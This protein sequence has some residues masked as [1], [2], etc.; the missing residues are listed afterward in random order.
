LSYLKEKNIMAKK[1]STGLSVSL[2]KLNQLGS[3]VDL[4]V[5]DEEE[6]Q[7]KLEIA[8]A[9]SVYGSSIFELEDGRAGYAFC[10]DIVNH[11]SRPIYGPQFELRRA[12][13]DP[14]FEWLPDPRDRH[15]NARNYYSFPG[16]GA[17]EFPRSQVLNHLLLLENGVL[18]PR[19]P[20]Q[21]YLLAVGG[22]MPQHL[23]HGAE[24]EPTLVVTTPGRTEYLEPIVLFTDRCS[25]KPK[26]RRKES[27]LYEG[28]AGNAIAPVVGESQRSDPGSTSSVRP[29]G[30]S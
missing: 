10:V 20:Y 28:P 15:R 7:A 29:L 27:S 18:Q 6:E 21:G 11:A 8:Q 30:R 23:H 22:P 14:D 9:G 26:L 17:P 12:W 3:P 5:A 24:V 25:V 19:V 4:S 1:Q 16:K 13:Q 2:R